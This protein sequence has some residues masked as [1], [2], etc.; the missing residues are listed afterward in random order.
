MDHRTI[1]GF[2]ADVFEPYRGRGDWCVVIG[3]V[4]TH[5][6]AQRMKEQALGAGSPMPSGRRC[7]AVK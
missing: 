6:D 4:L 7:A 3:E 2:H 1:Y 5:A